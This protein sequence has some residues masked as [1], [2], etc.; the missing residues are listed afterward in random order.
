MMPALPSCLGP[1]RRDVLRF[2]SVSVASAAL[3]PL[4]AHRAAAS[5]SA[6]NDPAVIFVWL[7]GGPPHQDTF[8][9]KPDAPA[10]YRGP[11]KPIKTTA[12]GIQICEHLPKLAR[13]AESSA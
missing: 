8:D 9:M 7:P 11:F 10:E 6:T 4:T 13:V 5:D 1:N 12:P 3:A 2:G